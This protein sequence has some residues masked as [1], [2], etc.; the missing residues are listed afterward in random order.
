MLPIQQNEI[1]GSCKIL[2]PDGTL[3]C[4]CQNDKIE[5]YL[6]RKL[7]EV[8]E[9]DPYLTIKLNFQPKGMGNAGIDFY[10]QDKENI[11]A[12]CG[13]TQDLTK[14]HCVPICY[15]KHMPD[16]Y[17]M[18][19]SHDILPLCA[20]CHAIYEPHANAFKRD[21]VIDYGIIIKKQPQ[22]NPQEAKAKKAAYAIIRHAY[23]MPLKRLNELYD[24]IRNFLGKKNFNYGDIFNL[25]VK[26]KKQ[27]LPLNQYKYIIDHTDNLDEFIK[28]WRQHFLDVMTP[29]HLPEF[30]TVDFQTKRR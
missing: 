22:V 5:W 7:A 24:I 1:Y 13:T 30:W 12:V 8:V 28:M 6:S 3:L 4:R 27:Y 11:C 16:D 23:Q 9:T 25:A 2:A 18:N 17:K 21:L 14:H 10:L 20:V 19:T 15:R 26:T 29:Q